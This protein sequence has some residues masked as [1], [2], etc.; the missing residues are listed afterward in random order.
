MTGLYRQHVNGEVAPV[1]DASVHGD[2]TVQG[3]LVLHVGIMEAGVQHD[4]GKRQDV[5]RVCRC[6]DTHTHTHK[7][8]YNVIPTQ[9]K[10]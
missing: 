9:R 2:E 8:N 1:V 10:G 3:G 4:D 7:G 5:A 6:R